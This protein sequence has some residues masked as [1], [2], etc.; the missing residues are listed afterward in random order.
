[1]ERQLRILPGT[2]GS[3]PCEIALN[4][5]LIRHH[6]AKLTRFVLRRYS[7]YKDGLVKL[8]A[9]KDVAFYKRMLQLWWNSNIKVVDDHKSRLPLEA[10]THLKCCMS[11]QHRK[12]INGENL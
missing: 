1:M 10:Y 3:L 12:A 7:Y 6:D 4:A 11:A 2:I 5:I 9:I 8:Q